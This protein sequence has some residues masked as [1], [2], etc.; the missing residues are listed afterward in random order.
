M[1]GSSPS[2]R[3]R[4]SDLGDLDADA[5]SLF[6]RPARRRAG[7]PASRASVRSAPTTADGSLEIL[8]TPV[9]DGASVEIRTGAGVFRGPD[10]VLQ[11]VDLVAT[12]EGCVA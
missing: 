6:L 1:P 3:I 2:T 12:A 8:L 10:H 11:I 4:L 9:S 7:R 5:F